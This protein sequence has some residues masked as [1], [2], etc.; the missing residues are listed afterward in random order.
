MHAIGDHTA[1]M[2]PV[3]PTSIRF[4]WSSRAL[5]L[6]GKQTGRGQLG[7]IFL[8]PA[9]TTRDKGASRPADQ[10]HLPMLLA[11]SFGGL[12]RRF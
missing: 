6:W 7:M 3:E 11:P 1:A 2:L 5:P 12:R 8:I 4:M 10:I 9:F